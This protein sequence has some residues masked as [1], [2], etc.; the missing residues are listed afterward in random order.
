[1]NNLVFLCLGV[2]ILTWS[3]AHLY[4]VIA[5]A[6]Q[7]MDHANH[8]S[9]HEGATPTGAGV[10]FIATFLLGLYLVAASGQWRE[11]EQ[12]LV[13]ILPGVLLVTVIGF[14]DDVRPLHWLLRAPLHIVAATWVIFQTSFPALDLLGYQVETSLLTLGFGVVALVWL[15]NLY[16]FMDGIDGIAASEALF[17][18]TAAAAAGWA[19]ADAEVGQSL[20]VLAA[21]CLGFLV[22]NW[23]KARVF[24][25]D[26]GS[27]F[28]GLML[29][30]LALSEFLV[31]VWSWVI[32]LGWFI[33]DACLTI[34]LRLYRGEKIQEAHSQHAYQH[35]NRALGTTNTLLLVH[36][37]NLLWLLP[38][39]CLAVQMQELGIIL[40]LFA[41]LPLLVLQFLCGAGQVKPR[42]KAISAK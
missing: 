11:L 29:G 5:T 14:I 19:L 32:L 26:G 38:L 6:V 10:A 25:G 33:T 36:A 1:V 27:N 28:L 41:C 16:N 37:L 31:P 3:L 4:R 17:V 9:A 40:L 7:I 12:M 20:L 22:I 15:L 18:I 39:A 2:V 34:C 35:L 23:P 8:R 13:D 24:M 21:A 30:A 42:L